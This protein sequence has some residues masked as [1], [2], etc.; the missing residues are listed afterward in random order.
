MSAP[1]AHAAANGRFLRSGSSMPVPLDPGPTD[2]EPR[3][4]ARRETPDEAVPSL[5]ALN[6]S[7]PPRAL[8]RYFAS[9]RKTAGIRSAS[10]AHLR[11]RKVVVVSRKV[12][13]EKGA[14]RALANHL[15][16]L[17][18]D[19]VEQDGGPARFFDGENDN[20]DPQTF[21]ARCREYPG[22]YR[23][24]VNPEDGCELG[25][26]K[27]YARRYVRAVELD[28]G[29]SIEWIGVGHHDT[30]RPHLH[31]VLRERTSEGGRLGLTRDYLNTGLRQ[32]A[33]T[34]ATELLGPR[35]ERTPSRTI[36]ADRFTNLD[37]VLI[38]AAGPNGRLES[39][40]LP[41]PQRP[42]ALRR[43]HY[44]ER[45]GWARRQEPTAW[46][47]RPDLRTVLRQ[48]AQREARELAAVRVVRNSDWRTDPSRLQA[49]VLNP[50]GHFAGAFIGVH[51]AGPY[52][53]S[54]RTVVIDGLEGRLGHVLVRDAKAVMCVDRIPSGAVIEAVGA[55]RAV[56]SSDQTIA[57]IAAERGGVWST[58]DHAEARP[59]DSPRFVGYHH[60]RAEAMSVE[61]ACTSLGDGRYAIPDDYCERANLVER[62][63]W[64]PTEISIRVLDDRRLEDQVRSPG[65]TWLD[66][67]MARA[68][69]P[70]LSGPFGE[71]VATAL[72]ERTRRL[73]MTGLGAGEPLRLSDA[74]VH[75]LWAMEIKSVIEPLE[76]TGKPVFLTTEGQR[77]AGVYVKRVHV[78]GAPY[79]VLDGKS[80]YH[81]VQ[82]TPGMEACRGRALNAV[83][84]DA[85]V[86]FR[87]VRTLGGELGL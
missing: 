37:L 11:G 56:R 13:S 77:A 12:V 83:V 84:Q 81:L 1:A 79:A 5:D 51:Q 62:N 67:L 26:M 18:R 63:Q 33:E 52:L 53:S 6:G 19:G 14:R 17:I 30:G 48:A 49:V 24:M 61:G 39:Q 4:S 35:I 55:P 16:Y 66:R 70:D 82:W 80:A 36:R 28:V 22:H 76:R 46:E 25:D 41:G 45:R 59:G 9:T 75:R 78:A 72:V 20:I 57:D 44:L 34:I 42:E 8:S 69:R 10:F 32:R 60:R 2:F 64:G 15:R 86:S 27:G 43:L 65:L 71:A 68:A 31:L 3:L 21:I 58:A 85:K 7:R 23:V 38:N 54:A 50:G 47:I 87:S 74:D 73:R 29:A 40:A